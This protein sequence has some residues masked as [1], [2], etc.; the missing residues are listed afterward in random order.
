MA[1]MHICGYCGK[2]DFKTRAEQESHE[3]RV[4]GASDSPI[5]QK[6]EWRGSYKVRPA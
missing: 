5:V 2:D 3:R 1:G 4:H 6:Y